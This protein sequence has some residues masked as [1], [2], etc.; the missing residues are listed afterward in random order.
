M[1]QI[2]RY[3]YFTA[4]ILSSIFFVGCEDVIQIDLNTIEPQIVLEAKISDDW[5]I[6]TLK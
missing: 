4:I 6:S 3:L 5:E 2:N 1:K